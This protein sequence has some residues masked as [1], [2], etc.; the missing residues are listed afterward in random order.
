MGFKEIRKSF[1]K[2][3]NMTTTIYEHE[4]TGAKHVHVDYNTTQ[5]FFNVT[6]KTLPKSSNGVAHI[7]EHSVLNGSK[8]YPIHGMFFAMQGRNFETYSNAL[9]GFTLT[10]YPFSTIDVK[11]YSNLMSV[12]T[13]AVFFPTLDKE[14]FLQEG[15]RYTFENPNDPYSK[16]NYGGVVFNEMIGAYNNADR[17]G[18]INLIQKVFKDTQ[19]E[20]F[21][22]G[23]PLDIPSLSY[24]E[25][26]NFHETYYHPSNATFY[27]FGSIKA[28]TI[29][30]QLER[31]VLSK[32]DKK[33]INTVVD[34]SKLNISGQEYDSVHPGENGVEYIKGYQLPQINSVEELFTL[35]ILNTFI[36][37]G[38]NNI[39][40]YFLKNSSEIMIEH[41]SLLPVKDSVFYFAFKMDE[42][43]KEEA[44]KLLQNYLHYFKTNKILSSEIDDIFEKMEMGLR[45][46]ESATSNL[47]KDIIAKYIHAEEYGFEK[48]EDIFSVEKMNSIKEKLKNS[49]YISQLIDA[50]FIN[51]P[52]YFSINSVASP[53][54]GQKMLAQLQAQL[55]Q[56]EAVI[57]EEERMRI[58]ND[59]ISL[60]KLRLKEKDLSILPKL[61][62]KDI[63]VNFPSYLDYKEE[64][65]GNFS[66]YNF[67]SNTKD[68]SYIDIKFPMVIEN[69]EE[70]FKATLI[71]DLMKVLNLNDLTLEET[72]LWRTNKLGHLTPSL[73]IRA[74]GHNKVKGF[75][76][77]K[78]QA[79]SENTHEMTM[80]ALEL[81]TQI[82]FDDKEVIANNILAMWREH[83]SSYQ[84]NALPFVIAEA[85]APFS[86]VFGIKKLLSY[87]YKMSYIK[88]IVENIEVGDFTFIDDLKSMYEKMFRTNALVFFCADERYN[89]EVVK[90][91]NSYNY[92][93][94]Q[95]EQNI[96]LVTT[97]N[98]KTALD[99]NISI[100]HLAYSISLKGIT[101]E[102]EAIVK[103]LSSYVRPYLLTNIREKGGAYGANSL[104]VDEVL[105]F[106]TSRD[107]NPQNS[108]S[109]FKNVFNYLLNHD[110]DE[111][112]LKID[113]LNILKQYNVP[114]EYVN[115]AFKTVNKMLKTT[116]KDENKYI[117]KILS[118][119]GN[120]IKEFISKTLLTAPVAVA[121]ASNSETIYENFSD[122]KINSLVDSK[123][124]SKL[125]VK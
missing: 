66:L 16:L 56:K 70:L 21:S 121:L 125:K 58:Y 96:N 11:G 24:E 7:L 106:Y 100:N 122:W 82:S 20:N 113:K 111:N 90:C 95:A 93:K 77:I 74:D 65:I 50:Y 89:S 109:T 104:Y 41:A 47:G 118:T 36:L 15:W 97:Y 64:K 98:E 28:Q 42:T 72:N 92:N 110:F 9:T 87:D 1:N 62:L 13:D 4:K 33:Y 29:Q 123:P 22:G 61:D 94:E 17:V 49:K 101:E 117:S 107:P 27:T 102:E 51:N 83:I 124:S 71:I 25:F 14:I 81:S 23:D 8:K 99:L 114:E 2:E 85:H 12:Y 3:L 86:E 59:N 6:F 55:A 18:V 120:E 31:D 112:Q 105:T 43:K 78:S 115:K 84:E 44:N 119:T 45:E 40:D 10:E 63:T 68:L 103:L 38:K 19:Y 67:N 91:L 48:F 69:N 88:K 37:S 34:T 108:L 32:F 5:N 30:E 79:L 35:E 46:G 76:E 26:K 53:D 116:Q 75:Y 39:Y 57:T 60:E 73:S 54:Y 80:K 52:K